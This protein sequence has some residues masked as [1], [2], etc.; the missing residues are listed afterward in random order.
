MSR[1]TAAGL[2]IAVLGA[3]ACLAYIHDAARPVVQASQKVEP[4]FAS[5]V[6]EINLSAIYST[7]SQKHLQDV[8]R[9]FPEKSPE[10]ER[11]Q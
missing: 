8:E 11:F 9:D 7:S 3:L 6:Q 5:D 4:A 2:V 1:L 10:I